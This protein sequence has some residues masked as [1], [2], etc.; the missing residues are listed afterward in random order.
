MS[1]E[2][3]NSGEHRHY[4]MPWSDPFDGPT[5]CDCEGKI[6]ANRCGTTRV[7]KNRLGDNEPLKETYRLQE[8]TRR[9]RLRVLNER[10]PAT[11]DTA[12][13]IIKVYFH[14]VYS[15]LL[16]NVSN[17]KLQQQIDVL[18]RDFRKQNS[19][20]PDR[21]A[22]RASDTRIGFSWDPGDVNRVSS[23]GKLWTP[24]TDNDAVKFAVGG[25]SDVVTPNLFLNIWI[26]NL[27]DSL[28]GYGL[29]PVDGLLYPIYDGVVVSVHTLPGVGSYPNFNMGRTLVHEVG[30]YLNLFHT[31]GDGDCSVD[32]GVSDTPESSGPS[33]QCNLSRDSCPTSPNVD[34]VENYMDY[35]YD[36]CMGLF[37]YGQRDRM[38]DC[39]FN[40]RTGIWQTSV[41]GDL[42][43]SGVSGV[44]G[45]LGISMD[46][47]VSNV[48]GVWSGVS[49][50]S[51]V[52][53]IA[54]SWYGGQRASGYWTYS[55]LSGVSGAFGDWE[56]SEG[57]GTWGV[58]G[59]WS[60]ILN[61]AGV[62]S[63]SSGVTGFLDIAGPWSG[64][65]RSSGTFGYSGYSNLTG[66]QEIWG[67][68][69]N[70][71]LSQVSARWGDWGPTVPAPLDPPDAARSVAAFD[72]APST[73]R[74]DR[75][76]GYSLKK[77]YFGEVTAWRN[78]E[79]FT[80][81]YLLS[82]ARPFTSV[83]FNT[84]KAEIVNEI[85]SEVTAAKSSINIISVDVPTSAEYTEGMVTFQKM[86]TVYEVRSLVLNNTD[87]DDSDTYGTLHSNYLSP[88]VN[89][90]EQFNESFNLE[91]GDSGEY[92][93]S[94]EIS[95]TA[96][97]GVNLSAAQI[98]TAIGE[99][100]LSSA[101]ENSLNFLLYSSKY[102]TNIEVQ[103][104]YSTAKKTFSETY[105]RLKNSYSFS[106]SLKFKV[107]TDGVSDSS[108]VE[109]YS[110][111]I[112]EEGVIKVS[113][114]L[115][116][117]G[118]YNFNDAL[119]GLTQAKL[120]S[121]NNCNA[122][123]NN[124]KNHDGTA[125]AN[126]LS[127]NNE[128]LDESY[129]YLQPAR[130]IEYSC[131]FSNDP[132]SSTING[133]PYTKEESINWSMDE[134]GIST[135]DVDVTLKSHG[136]KPN[137]KSMAQQLT[138][139][140]SVAM[141]LLCEVN[142]SETSVSTLFNGRY[143]TLVNQ[144]TSKISARELNGF[145]LNTFSKTSRSIATEA[146]RRDLN[147]IGGRNIS[148]KSSYSNDPTLNRKMSSR[149]YSLGQ[150][151]IKKAETKI[152]TNMPSDI[153]KEH[154]IIG[155]RTILNYPFKMTEGSVSAS[156][157]L[158]LNRPASSRLGSAAG[159]QYVALT[160]PSNYRD[161]IRDIIIR[162]IIPE[163]KDVLFV[164]PR[165]A[166]AAEVSLIFNKI[167]FNY[168]SMGD[169]SISCEAE[170][171]CK[172]SANYLQNVRIGSIIK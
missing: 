30:H 50:I 154:N 122:L 158:V 166:G 103:N 120:N 104:A 1:E 47:D 57:P 86:V 70:S 129:S 68:W 115:F 3:H 27:G 106:L 119:S 131:S 26:C 25:G 42:S 157:T 113:Q 72:S 32:D 116:I 74:C 117:L 41:D 55:N 35:S 121:F 167:S 109:K 14:V 75:T 98:A 66:D 138:D 51:G 97:D 62:W 105:D 37:T 39:L 22:N 127:L 4:G 164:E 53:D 77:E 34:M 44:S 9:E 58:S 141:V 111:D 11:A 69:E 168:S 67:S 36:A 144:V 59:V 133:S 84:I 52:S 147:S 79:T 128:V 91:K 137:Q 94:H 89:D 73:S 45:A 60:G 15:N 134:K 93:Y 100:L 90:I 87:L 145:Y 130:S 170:I 64:V 7:F 49:G 81:E 6:H 80:R 54:G 118:K 101:E 85:N 110:L 33:A 40:S 17:E 61:P 165:L 161:L 162:V 112:G 76:L 114:N 43:I 139:L 78:V 65:M 125:T 10:L 156:L 152:S 56:D 171:R 8:I 140:S 38:T 13:R 16:G 92:T 136:E 12:V 5:I 124:F 163:A 149:L 146:S 99:G 150:G 151:I 23:L 71:G 132:S 18:N 107:G 153:V 102:D 48:S 123:Y 29:F 19:D 160:N 95:F 31:W 88:Y 24:L 83:N 63:G 21:W 169:V 135:I 142:H 28:L 2:I 46:L 20:V 172:K 143:T 126:A 159:S 155:N 148:Y 108:F 96:R 82:E